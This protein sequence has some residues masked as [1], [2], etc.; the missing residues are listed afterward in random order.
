MLDLP[1]AGQ[2]DDAPLCT[3]CHGLLRDHERRLDGTPYQG[4]DRCRRRVDAD[5]A[6]LAG[7][8][9]YDEDGVIV[10]GLYAA[11]GGQLLPGSGGDGAR[12]GRAAASRPPLNLGILSLQARG[13]IV[14]VLQTWQIDWH[15][16]LGLLHPRWSG[17]LQ[18]QLDETVVE[19]RRH[20]L[21]AASEHPAWQEFV[22]EVRQAADACRLQVT[23]ER[24]ERPIAVC[25]AADGCGGVILV[26]VST[27]GARCG[28]CGTQYSRT[29][30][31]RLP[32]AAR[33]ATAA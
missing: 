6:A 2:P 25:C 21:W 3:S 24:K 31:V 14:T 26:T 18:H 20:L 30:A 16:T 27:P 17:D 1:A 32:V 28:R 11:L 8:P 9:V 23:G 7:E 5:L 22:T 13:G 29:E 10:T 15:E 33:S 12:T 4:C 19:L